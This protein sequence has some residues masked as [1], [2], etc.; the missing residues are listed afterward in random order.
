[1]HAVFIGV[2]IL[3]LHGDVGMS[4][5]CVLRV[6][7]YC[8]CLFTTVVCVVI[9]VVIATFVIVVVV[10][11]TVVCSNFVIDIVLLLL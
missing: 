1:M 9:V 2:A 7:C 8:H 11:V 4:T 6:T 3:L 5:R 10:V